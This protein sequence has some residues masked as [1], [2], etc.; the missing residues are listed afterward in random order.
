MVVDIADPDRELPDDNESQREYPARRNVASEKDASPKQPLS[1]A[2]GNGPVR[3]SYQPIFA[4][5]L[6]NMDR[7][8]ISDTFRL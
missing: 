3:W 1:G 7:S 8:V 5:A 4:F 6:A 2:C